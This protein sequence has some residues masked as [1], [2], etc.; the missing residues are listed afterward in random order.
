MNP[1]G[2]APLTAVIRNGG[3]TLSNISVRIVPKEGGQEIAYKVSDSEARTHGGIPIFGLYPDYRNT[4]EV[5]YTKTTEGRSERVEKETYRIYAGP[6]NIATAGYAGV[7]SVFPKA[8]VKKMDP[9]FKDRLYL[10]NNMI[11]ATP[12]TTSAQKKNKTPQA[13]EACGEYCIN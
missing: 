7:T 2:I 1:Y 12:N 8:T 9:A 3:Y 6:A 10:I 11:A 13:G 4:V 5:S